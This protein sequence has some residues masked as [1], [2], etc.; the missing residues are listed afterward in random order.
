MPK[1]LKR[2]KLMRALLEAEDVN[3]QQKIQ[4]KRLV[5]ERN[6]LQKQVATLIS[7]N[8]ELRQKNRCLVQLNESLLEQLRHLQE[9]P[10]EA[11]PARTEPQKFY[12]L[13]DMINGLRNYGKKK[14]PAD[15]EQ[16]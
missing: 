10:D 2:K 12:T 11:I 3:I 8:R 14:I 15:T 5:R 13:T 16:A 9:G 7:S 4:L 6:N 1:K